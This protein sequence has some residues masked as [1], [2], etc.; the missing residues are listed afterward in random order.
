MIGSQTDICLSDSQTQ[1]SCA[2][3]PHPHS[4]VEPY[5][6]TRPFVGNTNI[7]IGK[8]MD[9]CIS[10]Q[11]PAPV[12]HRHITRKIKHKDGSTE[13][14]TESEWYFV[15]AEYRCCRKDS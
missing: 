9:G 11:V 7:P 6:P 3:P 2:L 12:Q 10:S 8:S 5:T 14:V 1:V 13:E 4:Q 15:S